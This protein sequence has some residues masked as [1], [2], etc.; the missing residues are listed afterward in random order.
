MLKDGGWDIKV[1]ICKQSL[2]CRYNSSHP[3]T[4]N[5]FPIQIISASKV[6]MCFLKMLRHSGTKHSGCFFGLE[7][8]FLLK[9]LLEPLDSGNIPDSL[10]PVIMI[11]YVVTLSVQ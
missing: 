7:L 10:R 5:D 9:S 6:H 8:G 2:L 11:W 1:H 3:K 4:R